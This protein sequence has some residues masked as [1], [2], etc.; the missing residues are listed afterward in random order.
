[1]PVFYI[2]EADSK[3]LQQLYLRPSLL[4]AIDGLITSFVIVTGGIA[5]ES[6]NDKIILIGFSSLIADGISMGVSE[7]ISSRAENESNY[8]IPLIKGVVCFI[9]FVIVGCAT[10][11]GFVIGQTDTLRVTFS[12]CLFV[13]FM[14]G[15]GYIR[16]L[17]TRKLYFVSILE[18][19]LP[20]GVAGAIA[21]GIAS[22]R[23]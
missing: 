2:R 21:Y 22:I 5:S 7:F 10:L 11:I 19:V 8:Y 18:T 15:V 6:S 4:G 16:A 3:V 20:G 1:M 14:I 13:A 9:S 23:I 12:A 17:I